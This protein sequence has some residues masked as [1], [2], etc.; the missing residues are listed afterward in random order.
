MNNQSAKFRFTASLDFPK[1]RK[2]DLRILA[3]LLIAHSAFVGSPFWSGL[4]IAG[5]IGL[6]FFRQEQEEND[7]P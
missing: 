7:S 6:W 1:G 2:K 3:G 4:S 5:A